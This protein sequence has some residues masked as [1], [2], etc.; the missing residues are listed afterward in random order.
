M[1]SIEN[2]V[3]NTA[4]DVLL[5]VEINENQQSNRI[6]PP[7]SNIF[8]T[9]FNNPLPVTESL[10]ESKRIHTLQSQSSITPFE[11]TGKKILSTRGTTTV[12]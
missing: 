7:F 2:P 4:T 1:E 9:R 5:L 3:G 10:M 12:F 8:S 11:E 6:S